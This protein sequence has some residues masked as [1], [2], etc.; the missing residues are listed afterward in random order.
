MVGADMRFSSLMDNNTANPKYFK[1]ELLF[2]YSG[3]VKT[4]ANIHLCKATACLVSIT[5]AGVGGWHY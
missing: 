4:P 1:M 5:A 2:T 3:E